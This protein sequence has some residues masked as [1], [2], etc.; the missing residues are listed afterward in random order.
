MKR[1]EFLTRTAAGLSA[2]WVGWKTPLLAPPLLA[3]P[4]N[5]TDT[6][7]LGQTGIRTSRLACGTGTVGTNHHSRQ[8]DLGIPGLADLLVNGYD[9]GLRFFDTADTYGSHPHVAAAL[10][11]LPREKV[12]ILS[13][14]R[15]RDSRGMRADLDRFRREL[16][17]DYIDIVLMHCVTEDDWTT[18][19]RGAMDVLEEAREK[20]T[21]RAHGCSCHTLEALGAAARSSWVQVDLARLNPIGARMDSDPETVL[22]VLREM[23]TQGKAVIGMKILGEGAMRNR[24][25]EA[26]SFALSSGVLDAF[27]IGAES[28]TEQEDLIR[29]IHAVSV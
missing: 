28:R 8:S 18:R 11:R 3:G 23:K 10:K 16:D 22:S 21:V 4:F 7:V 6:V 24:V 12:T 19:F 2:A 29:R 15:S 26:L 25:D 20:G 27:T 14:S 13:K 17:T 9:H 5:A 1:R